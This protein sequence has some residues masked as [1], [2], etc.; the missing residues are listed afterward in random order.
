M[1]THWEAWHGAYA[2]PTSSL[3]RRLRVVQDHL[4]RFL[5]ETAPR[6]V[7]VLSLCA[8]E[9]RDLLEVLAERDDAHR[10]AATLVELDPGLADRA[11]A[12]AAAFPGVEVRTA[13]AGDPETYAGDPPADLVLL[14][15]IFGNVSDADIEHTVAAVPA[16]CAPRAR[17]IW[18]R[19][20]RPPDLTPQ[21]REWFTH[22]GFREVAF[23]PVPDSMAAVGVAELVTPPPSGLGHGRLFTFVPTSSNARTLEVYEQHADRYRSSLGTAPDWHIAFLDHVAASLPPEA[24]VLELGSGTGTERQ[25]PHRPRPGRPALRRRELVPRGDAPGG[26]RSATDRRALRRPRRSVG[27]RRRLRCAAPPD[28]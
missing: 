10:V 21:V 11:R 9:G 7:R 20:R 16:L 17:V 19:T 25:V 8:G 1:V 13:D 5:D 4:R 12:S 24:S 28:P 14:C 22:N 6:P 2:D 26:T 23:D 18:T 3:S 15:G 27:R